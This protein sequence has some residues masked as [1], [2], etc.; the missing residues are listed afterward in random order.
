MYVSQFVW[1]KLSNQ[2]I[3]ENVNKNGDVKNGNIHYS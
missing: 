2:I 3:K 1:K